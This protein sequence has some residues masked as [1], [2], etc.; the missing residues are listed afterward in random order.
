MGNSTKRPEFNIHI[1]PE[2]ADIVFRGLGSKCTL[3]PW[4]TCRATKISLNWKINL[5]DACGPSMKFLH[6]I[7]APLISNKIAMGFDNFVS[8][9]VLLAVIFLKENSSIKDSVNHS[10]GVELAGKYTRGQLIVLDHLDD[11]DGLKVRI[12]RTAC[13]EE[14]Q[15]L[16]GSLKNL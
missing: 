5:E 11:S 13:S 4:E 1:D 15:Y 8:S 14:Y 6:K 7:E 2:A 10:L 3:L 16:I 9:D 12:V